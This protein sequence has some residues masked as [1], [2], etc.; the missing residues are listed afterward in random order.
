[1]H[2]SR[3]YLRVLEQIATA[4]AAIFVLGGCTTARTLDL[5]VPSALP[6]GVE[7]RIDATVVTIDLPEAALSLE[8]Q[9]ATPMYLWM[10]IV[11]KHGPLELD[12]MSVQ[13]TAQGNPLALMSYLGPAKPWKSARALY[14]GCGPRSYEY[15][16]SYSKVD[17]YTH[18]MRE[19]NPEVGIHKV[20][21]PPVT[22][23]ETSCLI[24]FFDAKPAPDRRY[25]VGIASLRSGDQPVRVPALAFETG[26]LRKYFPT[27]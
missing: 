26:V 22:I 15:Y 2:A 7:G 20:P 21:A 5:A 1:M 24:F 16:W 11:P 13:L 6:S 8:V 27:P 10:K 25:T 9:E 18:E 14:Q 19:G 3:H 17:V 4:F 12:P 23:D